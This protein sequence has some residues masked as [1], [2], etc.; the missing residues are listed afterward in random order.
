MCDIY[1]K[2]TVKAGKLKSKTSKHKQNKNKQIQ[3]AGTLC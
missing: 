2:L 3:Y 1:S